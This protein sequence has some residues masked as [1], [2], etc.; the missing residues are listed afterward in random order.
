MLPDGG[1]FARGPFG[2]PHISAGSDGGEQD[3]MATLN[4]LVSS[5]DVKHK[6]FGQYAQAQVSGTDPWLFL[7]ERCLQSGTT[8]DGSQLLQVMDDLKA[9]GAIFQ[10]AVM[11]SSR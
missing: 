8:F 5:L 2:S 7:S 6:Y 11:V 4:K 3:S 1:A 10:P 9:S